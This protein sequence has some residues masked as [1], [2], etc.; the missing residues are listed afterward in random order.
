ML[1]TFLSPLQLDEEKLSESEEI[2]NKVDPW[3]GERNTFL[4]PLG[5]ASSEARIY[6]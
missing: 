2:Q 6:P 5:S 1:R 4:E 3:D